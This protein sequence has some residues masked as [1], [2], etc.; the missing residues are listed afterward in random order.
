MASTEGT[1]FN[2]EKDIRVYCMDF[3][4]NREDL[5]RWL[6]KEEI[7]KK[8]LIPSDNNYEHNTGVEFFGD[9][10]EHFINQPLDNLQ[11]SIHDALVIEIAVKGQFTFKYEKNT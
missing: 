9:L 11:V 2:T 3:K 10:L 6:N 8:P 4:Y 5:I 1:T 7:D